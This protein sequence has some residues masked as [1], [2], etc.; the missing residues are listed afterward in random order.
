ME[1][2]KKNFETENYE[3]FTLVTLTDE[4]E[5]KTTKITLGNYF[6]KEFETEEQAKKYID[7][8]PYEIIMALIGIIT[9]HIINHK[10]TEEK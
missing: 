7:S 5:N 9:E 8:K 6:I 1:K 3:C 4:N 2:N 10:K